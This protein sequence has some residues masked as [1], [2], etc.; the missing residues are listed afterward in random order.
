MRPRMSKAKQHEQIYINVLRFRQLAME[1]KVHFSYKF[2]H[3]S[4]RFACIFLFCPSY[5]FKSKGKWK[6]EQH[7]LNVAA[8]AI[9]VSFI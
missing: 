8:G 7:I 6:R 1:L 9:V 5:G 4:T 2:Y 3:S